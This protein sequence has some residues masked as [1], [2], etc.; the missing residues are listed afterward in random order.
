M[1]RTKCNFVKEIP[2][3]KM[4]AKFSSNKVS[5]RV[6]QKTYLREFNMTVGI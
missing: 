4:T 2:E 5:Y 3:I 6:K 1:P